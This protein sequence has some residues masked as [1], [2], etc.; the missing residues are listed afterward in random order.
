[1]LVIAPTTTAAAPW[2]FG[3]AYS[4]QLDESGS[5]TFS[6][7]LFR[8][9]KTKEG[10]IL[11][12]WV[13]M[14]HI[15]GNFLFRCRSFAQGLHVPVQTSGP[16]TGAQNLHGRAMSRVHAR[17]RH[18]VIDI[19]DLAN[20]VRLG[21]DWR[22][23]WDLAA[24]N[25]GLDP[26]WHCDA[27]LVAEELLGRDGKDLVDFLEGELLGLA[28]ETEDHEPGDQVQAG[29]ETKG[30]GGCHDGLHAGEC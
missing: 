25:V 23:L 12:I 10:Q 20:S 24:E 21:D 5:E 30:A 11:T 13:S 16:T 8:L 1:M 7:S 27:Q 9:C 15:A 18:L 6:Q 2:A 28:H 14:Q 22:W 4:G 19:P 29:V 17:V 26:V 3:N